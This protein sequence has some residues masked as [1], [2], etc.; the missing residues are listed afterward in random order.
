MVHCNNIISYYLLYMFVLSLCNP[1]SS[2]QCELLRSE[3]MLWYRY[4]IQF[5]FFFSDWS[6]LVY[7]FRHSNRLRLFI[8]VAE[9]IGYRVIKTMHLFPGLGRTLLEV[10]SIGKK[11]KEYIIQ[12]AWIIHNEQ[13][14][15]VIIYKILL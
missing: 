2:A 10:K 3:I 5:F 13:L 4:I 1:L 7:E 12:P 15:D 9:S 6:T 11:Q 8:I 14:H